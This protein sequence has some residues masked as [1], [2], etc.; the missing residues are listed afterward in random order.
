MPTKNMH[1]LPSNS[2]LYRR[3]SVRQGSRRLVHADQNHG[4]G[5]RRASGRWRAS[6]AWPG[7]PPTL[8]PGP[9]PLLQPL[10]TAVLCTAL[11][12]VARSIGVSRLGSQSGGLWQNTVPVFAALIAALIFGVQPLP[13]P[14]VGGAVVPAAVIYMQWQRVRLAVKATKP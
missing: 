3:T 13:E 4:N 11:A 2:I 10:G 8:A 5:A 12:T 9:L 6:P 7:R 14:L 1:K